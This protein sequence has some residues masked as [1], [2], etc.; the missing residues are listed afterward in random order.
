MLSIIP[1]SPEYSNDYC[2]ISFVFFFLMLILLKQNQNLTSQQKQM[3]VVSTAKT[4]RKTT[5]CYIS[6]LFKWIIDA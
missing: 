1:S 2:N 4:Q 6:F 5:L 3:L